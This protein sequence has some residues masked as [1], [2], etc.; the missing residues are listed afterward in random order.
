MDSYIYQASV[1]TYFVGTI[2]LRD[3]YSSKCSK[4]NKKTK[5]SVFV[6]FFCCFSCYLLFI[7]FRLSTL[8]AFCNNDRIGGCT[9]YFETAAV[10]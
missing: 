2:E 6:S 1:D 4:Q 7:L 8:Y 3:E 9:N 5:C 10:S